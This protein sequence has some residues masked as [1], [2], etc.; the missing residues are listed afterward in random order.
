MEILDMLKKFSVPIIIVL[1]L[2]LAISYFGVISP[3][4]MF[5]KSES[6]MAYDGAYEQSARY[7]YDEAMADFAPEVE[8]RKIA[9]SST[10]NSEVKRGT[11]ETANTRL[12]EIVTGTEGLVINEN[13]RETR[14]AMSGDYSLRVPAQKYDQAITDLKAIGEVKL[15]TENARDVTGHYVNN[16]IELQV[17][18]ERLTRLQALYTSYGKIDDKLKLEN[19]IF[20]QERKIKYL[21]DS[22][23]RL[24]QKIEYS[25]LSVK[26]YEP[27]SAWSEISF[28]H[29]GDLV[30]TFVN[31]VKAFLY[32]FFAVLP[33]AIGLLILWYLFKILRRF[34]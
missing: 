13:I 2:L 33:W 22:L 24:D 14:G 4:R 32:F 31:S 21:E 28:L 34:L 6:M 5:S 7:G 20:E 18:R 16:D 29:F 30:K 19:A 10:L 15:F 9:K 12:H 11:F 3:S 26:I 17:E 1:L 27:E 25:T 8:E 23:T